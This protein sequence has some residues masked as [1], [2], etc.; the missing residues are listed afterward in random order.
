MKTQNTFEKE[1]IKIFGRKEARRLQKIWSDIF[2]TLIIKRALIGPSQSNN[3]G[4]AR[5]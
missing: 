3:C 4:E 5:Q 1:M 2:C